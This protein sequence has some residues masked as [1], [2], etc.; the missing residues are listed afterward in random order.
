MQQL[1]MHNNRCIDKSFKFQRM[2]QIAL[3][4]ESLDYL[5]KKLGAGQ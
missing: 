5:R 4:R 1:Q 3:S 2:L